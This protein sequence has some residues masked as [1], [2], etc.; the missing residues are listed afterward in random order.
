MASKSHQ[1]A[2]FGRPRDETQQMIVDFYE[3]HEHETGYWPTLVE[4][5]EFLGTDNM[6]GVNRRVSELVGEGRLARIE[7]RVITTGIP[8]KGSHDRLARVKKLAKAQAAY[9]YLIQTGQGGPAMKAKAFI[10]RCEADLH[11]LDLD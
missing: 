7:R 2:S 10:A 5:A 3:R 1:T 4:V 9:I 11:P 6:Q 8:D